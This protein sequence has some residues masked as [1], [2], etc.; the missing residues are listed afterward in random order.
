[1]SQKA[2]DEIGEEEGRDIPLPQVYLSRFLVSSLFQHYRN[3]SPLTGTLA[4]E[5]TPVE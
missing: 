3:T 2:I 5:A 1:M 4:M